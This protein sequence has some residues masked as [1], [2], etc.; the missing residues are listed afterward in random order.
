MKPG[1]REEFSR[2]LYDIE[3]FY[4]VRADITQ[5]I[6]GFACHIIILGLAESKKVRHIS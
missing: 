2:I 5:S 4:E 3:E 6:V 1:S